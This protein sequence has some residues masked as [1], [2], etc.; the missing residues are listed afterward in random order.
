MNTR[1]KAELEAHAYT[2]IEEINNYNPDELD[3][4]LNDGD[5]HHKL[6]NED[7][8]IIG[9][10]QAQEWLKSH[11]I[12][13]FQGID[14]CRTM[15]NDHFGEAHT[16]F[17]NAE[18]LVNHIVYWAGYDLDLEAIVEEVREDAESKAVKL[19]INGEEAENE[20]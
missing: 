9:Y 3:Q 10:Y 12:D 13:T 4:L 17:D 18:T 11:E 5:L 7:Y 6:F 16:D 14:Y 19:A 15:E 8:Y 20:K 1:I 2:Q